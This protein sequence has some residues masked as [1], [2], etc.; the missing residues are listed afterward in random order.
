MGQ[1]EQHQHS[2]NR[3]ITM[4]TGPH[5][6]EGTG[7]DGKPVVITY[8]VDYWADICACGHVGTTGSSTRTG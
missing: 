6:V 7:P 5:A 3:V 2:Y 4:T 1:G 8:H